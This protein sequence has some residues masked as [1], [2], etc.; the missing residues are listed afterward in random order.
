MEGWEVPVKYDKK[1]ETAAALMFKALSHPA[2]IW[3]VRQLAKDEHCVIEFVKALDVEFATVSRHLSILKAAGIIED[4]KRGKEV[5]YRLACPCIV[6][7]I[8]C[9]EARG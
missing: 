6:S 3:I 1:K 2:R 8:D 9:F 7:M 4:D 5:W